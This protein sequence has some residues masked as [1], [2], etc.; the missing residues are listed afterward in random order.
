MKKL[1]A[2]LVGLTF[3]A[4]AASSSA[5]IN[6]VGD[7][8]RSWAQPDDGERGLHIQQ[9]IDASPNEIPSYLVQKIRSGT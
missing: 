8:G 7:P 5:A 3:V 1:L 2:V 9:F 6:S 4:G